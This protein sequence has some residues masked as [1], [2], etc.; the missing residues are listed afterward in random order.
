MGNFQLPPSQF[1]APAFCPP[2][3]SFQHLAPLPTYDVH[4]FTNLNF[5]TQPGQFFGV[6]SANQLLSEVPAFSLSH[7]PKEATTHL[8]PVKFTADVVAELVHHKLPGLKMGLEAMDHGK[9]VYETSKDIQHGLKEGKNPAETV[10]CETTKAAVETLIDAAGKDALLV[11]IPLYLA[12]A[13]AF[14]PLAA[15][16]PVV[17]AMLPDA[18]QGIEQ[19][20]KFSGQSAEA[21]CHS[22]FNFARNLSNGGK[23]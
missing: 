17:G 21:D 11:G 22:L 15:T 16:I 12:E 10:V 6:S 8:S 4:H 3:P 23:Q 14:P 19:F 7:P 5:N 2:V 20:A 9:A 1:A 18:Y 13:A